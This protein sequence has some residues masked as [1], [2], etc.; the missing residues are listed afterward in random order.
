MV[1]A[2]A[3]WWMVDRRPVSSWFAVIGH[4][5][6]IIGLS[7]GVSQ[8]TEVAGGVKGGRAGGAR[9]VSG[10]LSLA[11]THAAGCCNKMKPPP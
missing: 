1:A 6:K 9:L 2:A 3:G 8:R 5:Q 10:A 4:T 7:Q 11:L